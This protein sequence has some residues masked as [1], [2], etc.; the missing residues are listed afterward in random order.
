MSADP[1]L[2]IGRYVLFDRIAVGGMASVY[3]ARQLG[4]VGFSR[5]VAVKRLHEQYVHDEKFVEMFIDE[6]RLASRL[7]HPNVVA[8][9]DVIE[10]DHELLLV[11]DYVH[12]VSLG[13]LART[14]PVP[15][16][17]V[18]AVMVD[19]LEGLHA[20]HEATD[21]SGAPLGIVHRDVS[22][23]NI[24]VGADGVSRI[25]DFGIAKAHS[26]VQTTRD[27]QI[28]GKLRYMPPEQLSG[29]A[30]DRRSDVYAAAVVAWELLAGRALVPEG[31]VVVMVRR[32]TSD[33]PPPSPVSPDD[34]RDIPP[35]F[36]AAVM[37]GL[38]HDPDDRHETAAAL[39]ADL[40][41]PGVP[42]RRAHVAAWVAEVA[43]NKLS[44]RDTQLRAVEQAKLPETDPSGFGGAL[45]RVVERQRRSEEETVD[46]TGISG[47]GGSPEDEVS[48]V[49]EASSEGPT[50][51]APTVEEEITFT[52]AGMMAPSTVGT[53]RRRWFGMGAGV[54]LAV[55]AMAALVMYRPEVGTVRAWR[56]VTPEPVATSDD[57]GA[58]STERSSPSAVASASSPPSGR[59]SATAASSAPPLDAP[60]LP[61]RSPTP[62]VPP[63]TPAAPKTDCTPPYVYVDGIKR[64][65]P[66]CF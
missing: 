52:P 55:G 21:E 27:G 63:R 38:S 25:I 20:A 9:T 31:D 6:A 60:P 7:R 10:T 48:G 58:G 62:R 41:L 44:R 39:S 32:I 16:E 3:L 34:D 13:S 24:I 46:E 47:S 22:P 54:F 12:G 61:P 33:E 28:K 36:V 17:I 26:R 42:T 11:M 1:P 23:Q 56:M 43:G 51:G 40:R 15:V 30:I 45:R 50:T 2:V 66:E 65:K 37:R 19:A 57:D 4:P 59:A 14:G 8:A 18:S 49:A 29:G 5:T 64:F 53:P 35:V